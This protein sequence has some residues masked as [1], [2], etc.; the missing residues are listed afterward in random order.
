MNLIAV[1]PESTRHQPPGNACRVHVLVVGEQSLD[2]AAPDAHTRDYMG[3]GEVAIRCAKADQGS[4]GKVGWRLQHGTSVDT[5]A[6]GAV[7]HGYAHRHCP[8]A[9]LGNRA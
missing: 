8:G 9:Q 7:A 5:D 3:I 4:R 6:D 1:A 2:S